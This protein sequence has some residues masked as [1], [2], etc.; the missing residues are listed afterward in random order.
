MK[1]SFSAACAVLWDLAK[2][3]WR[4]SYTLFKLMV[5]ILILVKALEELG[6]FPY[7][8]LVFQPLMSLVGLPESMGLVWTTTL[9]TNMYGGMI[10][11]FQLA[12]TEQLTVAQ[13]TVLATLLLM[14]HSLP[15]E[16]R[17]VQKAG[18]RFPA[19]LLTRLLGA[20]LLAMLMNAIYTLGDFHQ[21][22]VK[23][24]WSPQSGEQ[25]LIQWAWDQ[26]QSMVMIVFIIG[27][28]LGFLR[29][30][31]FVG[32]ERL[33][34]RLL[35]PL[36]RFLGIGPEATSLT[37]IGVTLGLSFGGGLLIQESRA[38]HISDRD[39]F[40]SLT[41]LGLCHSMIEDTLL[42]LMMG[43]DISGVLWLRLAFGLCVVA[44]VA[45]LPLLNH[46]GFRARYLVSTA[47]FRPH[48]AKS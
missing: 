38:G 4:V 35:Q 28:L 45:R 1:T 23:L 7:I 27:G 48:S 25:T 40:L 6:A 42:A 3:T 16:V 22:P 19:A 47:K 15:V 24:L 21:E 44:L 39:I 11:F 32:I 18:V 37:I 12:A 46:K 43:A 26:I 20:L 2:E 33:M 34:I 17:I 8:N 10:V 29:F 36:L 14:A 30:L 13:V 41:L 31:R 5:P 9:L